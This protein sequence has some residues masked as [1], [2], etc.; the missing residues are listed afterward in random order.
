MGKQGPCYHCGVTSEFLSLQYEIFC[1][2]FFL[3]VIGFFEICLF[4]YEV[5]LGTDG[6]DCDFDK[7]LRC[8]QGKSSG[9]FKQMG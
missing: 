1:L 8:V 4:E 9:Q 3:R 7:K 5:C 6:M 2:Q